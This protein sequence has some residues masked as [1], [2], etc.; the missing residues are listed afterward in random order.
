MNTQHLLPLLGSPTFRELRRQLGD[1]DMPERWDAC[2]LW[3]AR[4][5]AEPKVDLVPLWDVAG[6]PHV[7]PRRFMGIRIRNHWGTKFDVRGK[8]PGDPLLV[9]ER[10]G[11]MY[12]VMIDDDLR[13]EEHT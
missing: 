1:A 8:R 11:F 5:P 2:L 4:G 13:S 9:S 12:C 7:S 3:E 6:R 10:T